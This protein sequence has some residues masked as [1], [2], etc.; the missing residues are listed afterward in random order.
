MGTVGSTYSLVPTYSPFTYNVGINYNSWGPGR[1]GYS[2]PTDLAAISQDFKMIRTYYDVAVGTADPT[3]PIIEPTQQQVITYITGTSDEMLV[4]GT[5][6]S[7]LAQGGYGTPWSA[8]LMTSSAY[9]DAWVTMLINAFGSVANVTAHLE[10]ILLGNEIDANGPPP[11]DT[12]DFA[13]YQ[14]WIQQSFTNLKASLAA[15]GLGSIPV[16]TT[17]ANYGSTNVISTMATS[18]IE[19]N[20]SSSW[21]G[22][23]PFVMYNQYTQATTLGPMSSTNFAPVASYFQGVETTLAGAVDVFVGETGY[24]TYYN[25]TTANNQA[26]VYNQIFSWLDTMETANN[27]KTV[28][29][30]LFQAFDL[31]SAS[32]D[33]EQQ[34]GIYAQT[35]TSQPNGLKTGIVLPSWISTPTA[36][37]TT[38]LAARAVALASAGNLGSLH[39]M[40][41]SGLTSLNADAA[42]VMD[43]VLTAW[44][45]EAAQNASELPS[46]LAGQIGAAFAARGLPV[47]ADLTALVQ[48]A[49]VVA[50]GA[51]NHVGTDI[52]FASTAHSS[53][54]GYD[55][56]TGVGIANEALLPRALTALAQA[57]TYFHT[58]TVLSTGGTG[59]VAGTSEALLFQPILADASQVSL[60]I[61][62]TGHALS[63]TAGDAYAWS[64]QFAQQTLQAGFSSA[65][66]TLFDHQ[67]QTAGYQA[68]VAAGS[69]VAVGIDS[70]AAGTPQISLSNGSGFVD[71]VSGNEAVHVARAVAVAETV[72]AAD[73][74]TAVVRLRQAGAQ[75]SEVSFYKVDDFAG[76]INGLKPGD[77]GYE[78]ASLLRTY[79]TAEGATTVAGGGY[80]AYSESTIA[81]V[82]AGDLIAMRLTSGGHTYYAFAD[83]NET[84]D[85]QHVS[86]L[87]NYGL[88]TWGF[89]DLYGGG[90]HDYNDLVVQL[91]FTS[92][93]APHAVF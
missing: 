46:A 11:S 33:Y 2:I 77:A 6:N 52:A 42:S 60:T 25:T 57:Q 86:H 35:S 4:M 9:T 83:A 21:N 28:P 50:P 90:D 5:F 23:S 30:F 45:T 47:P 62:G 58:P 19:T 70:V 17:I 36:D 16:S 10:A 71:F 8:G 76:T 18:Y 20:W 14:T 1:T 63:G 31:P 66:V 91:D 82:N 34:F 22:G 39:A 15:Q 75:A 89:E 92:L 74:Q 78:L 7:A 64:S 81:H 69:S 72:A 56:I 43:L 54:P 27:G 87:W 48:M 32:P 12:I 29:M 38:A 44:N 88:N 53:G 41:G 3:T 79:Q 13:N 40:V 65:L 85:G 61:D 73:D 93:S 51:F 26:T 80:G 84:V 49:T 24:S 67:S 59:V 37:L 68:T 55:L